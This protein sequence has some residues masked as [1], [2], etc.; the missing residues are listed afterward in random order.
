[1]SAGLKHDF[2]SLA[3]NHDLVGKPC[4][5]GSLV[6]GHHWDQT[7][8]CMIY[9]VCTLSTAVSCLPPSSHQEAGAIGSAK[10]LSCVQ[11]GFQKRVRVYSST[12]LVC[13]SKLKKVHESQLDTGYTLFEMW[14]GLYFQKIWHLSH[15]PNRISFVTVILVRPDGKIDEG[16]PRT[17]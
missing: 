9:I 7:L 5:P 10:W 1:M 3:M 6:H 8:G 2:K 12:L 13:V 4:F 17:Q 11:R 15:C 14:K 16:A